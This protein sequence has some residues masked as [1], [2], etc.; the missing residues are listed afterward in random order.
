M[1]SLSGFLRRLARDS[2][3]AGVEDA[4]RYLEPHPSHDVPSKLA[5]QLGDRLKRLQQERHTSTAAPN[6]TAQ[7]LPQSAASEAPKSPTQPSAEQFE[8]AMQQPSAVVPPRKRG[9]G[10][11]KKETQHRAHKT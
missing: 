8:A 10:R 11:R 5:E 2:V 9:P 6:S 1:I 3:L 7:H 4:L